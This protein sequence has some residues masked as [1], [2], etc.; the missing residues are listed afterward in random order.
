MAAL[1]CVSR[2]R[3]DMDV[4]RREP[5][6][7][8]ARLDPV[9]KAC[10]I[11]LELVQTDLLVLD[12]QVDLEL[13]DTETDGN[14]RRRTP[15]Q[16]VLLNAADSGL[17]S[18]HV[19]LIV[20]TSLVASGTNALAKMALTPR[21]HIHG[22]DRLG[23]RLRLALLLLLVFGQALLA[24]PGSLGILLLVVASEQVH[25]ILVVLVLGRSLGGVQGDLAR[26]GAIGGVC[27]GGIASERS[28]FTFV[29]G[30]VLV[31]P[32]GMGVLG[33]GGRLQ[34]LEASDISL[35]G[36]IAMEEASQ[37]T[38][39]RSNAQTEESPDSDRKSEVH[40]VLVVSFSGQVLRLPQ[41]HG[42]MANIIL[43]EGRKS[44]FREG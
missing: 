4:D 21:L 44:T 40:K 6:Y 5:T 28:E 22:D 3:V 17:E 26:F 14:E 29:R 24:D 11:L 9:F 27:L 31:P 38:S 19:G 1:K 37:L 8:I 16:A 33:A 12:N 43:S 20:Y 41:K 42:P 18:C 23:R 7:N 35:A 15:N 34:G 10:D 25:V 13:L 30:N 39:R 36:D 32:S 2:E